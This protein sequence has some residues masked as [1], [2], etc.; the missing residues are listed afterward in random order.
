MS[1]YNGKEFLEE[2]LESIINQTY[3]DWILFVRDD[4]SSDESK[5]IIK[6]YVL[7]DERI[8]L[9]EDP[10]V[11]RG[12]KGSFIN[13]LTG[14]D[15]KYYLFCDQDDIWLPHKIELSYSTIH[16]L[17]EKFPGMPCLVA[18]DLTIVD[19]K[20]SILHNSMWGHLGIAEMVKDPSFL[21]VAPMYTGCTMMFNNEAKKIVING[22]DSPSILH[23][24][25]VSLN[26][27][28]SGGHITAI[29][30]P[31]IL[32]R[33]HEKNVIGAQI[34]HNKSVFQVL[35]ASL[36]YYKTISPIINKSILYFLYKKIVRIVKFR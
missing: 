2:Q 30:T 33:Q 11:H 13:L 5:L 18:S 16:K 26:V 10:I 31:T 9:V 36:S 15:A 32:Y 7:K 22:Y 3:K 19:A 34:T 21:I 29:K 4:G 14:V 28:R 24:Q 17:E 35:K 8:R 20:G 6:K 23:D 12:V 27:Y 25:L 1:T